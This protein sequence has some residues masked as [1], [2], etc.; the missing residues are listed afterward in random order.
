MLNVVVLNGGR[1]AASIIPA[2]LS[3]EGLQ[4]TSVVNAY[5]DG[6]STG[7]IRRFFNMLGPSDIRKVQQLM[8]PT[9]DPNY[10]SYRALYEHR[11]G[12]MDDRDAILADMIRFRDGASVLA[13]ISIDSHYTASVLRTFVDEFLGALKL[14]EAV[15]GE[16]FSFADC[17]LM[18]C[19]YAGAH[20]ALGRDFEA[21]TLKMDR[22]FRLKGTVFPNSIEN[23][24][25]A[26]I[27]ENGEVLYRE[28]EIVELRS[29]VLIERIYLLEQPIAPG[30]LEK[31]DREERK[32]FLERHHAPAHVSE[33]VRRSLAQADIIIY[34][35]GTQHSSLYP[36]YLSAGLGETIAG[37][38]SAAKIFV[39]NI[40]AD[41]ETPSYAASDFI[42]GAYRYICLGDGREHPFE[43]LF[44]SVLVNTSRLKPEETYV[45][46]DVPAFGDL[47]IELI[48]DDFEDKNA[49]GKH[50]GQTV[51]SRILDIYE[52]CASPRWR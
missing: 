47:S 31:L 29:N 8:L 5:D 27:R 26:A 25:L 6:K 49:H 39:T 28:A 2:L 22:L 10:G 11:Y 51:V 21:V 37:N 20:L 50:D 16:R 33:G 12:D 30:S 46:F 7:E 42:R 13:N 52:D 35:A 45:E 15:S 44:T 48:A 18:N 19:L 3:R 40:G 17:S 34:S 41:Y 36:T 43:Q 32:H 9:K 38:Q 23:R 24:H 14:I 1:G 4:V